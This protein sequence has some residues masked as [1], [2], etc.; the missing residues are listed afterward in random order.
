MRLISSDYSADYKILHAA[1]LFVH[2]SLALGPVTRRGP[3]QSWPQCEVSEPVWPSSRA[4]GWQTDAAG[5]IPCFGT[6]FSS[7]LVNMHTVL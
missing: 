7:K 1:V 4:L 2:P 6:T 5:S 3:A